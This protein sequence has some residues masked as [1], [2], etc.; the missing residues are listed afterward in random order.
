MAQF[1]DK[2]LTVWTTQGGFLCSGGNVMTA[3]WGF[4]GVMWGKRVLVVPVR[5]TRYTKTLLDKTGEFTFSVPA[6][7]EMKKE[8]AYCGRVSGRDVDKFAESGMKKQAARV[9][10]GSTV[11]G[12]NHYFECKVL[13]VCSM[14]DCDISKVSSN[15]KDGDLHNFYF[16]EIVAEY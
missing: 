2:N 7:G 4:I 14:K 5:D 12:C 16:G 9:T 3:S 1:E 6:E 13:T 15:Y 11:G 10:G 8:L